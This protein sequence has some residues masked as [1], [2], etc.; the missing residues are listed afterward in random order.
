MF[1]AMLNL[2][3]VFVFLYG[4]IWLF[5]RK[6]REIDA[7]QIAVPVLVPVFAAF[8][9]GLGAVALGLGAVGVWT[10]VVVLIGATYLSLWKIMGLP[11]MRSAGYTAAVFVFSIGA[12]VVLDPLLA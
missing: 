8:L 10:S 9:V 7:F 1:R 11:G 5:E 4:L 3:L 12:R 6:H 2:F